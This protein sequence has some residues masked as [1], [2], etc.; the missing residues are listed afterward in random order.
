MPKGYWIVQVT[1]TDP[2]R[3]AQYLAQDREVL[4]RYGAKPIVRGGR[5]EAPEG[6]AHSRQIVLEFDSFERAVECYRSPEY[7]A[8]MQHRLAGSK[9]DIVI[10]EGAD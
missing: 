1:V 10:V 2:D 4:A 3:Y 8:A 6:E 9:S 5:C 7:Q